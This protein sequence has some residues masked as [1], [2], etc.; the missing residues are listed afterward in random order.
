MSALWNESSVLLNANSYQEMWTPVPLVSHDPPPPTMTPGLGWDGVDVT[1][2]WTEIYKN[3]AV[4]GYAA[5]ISLYEGDGYGVAVA[6]NLSAA[7]FV[8]NN[9]NVATI[10]QTIHQA[11]DSGTV[12][13]VVSTFGS[14]GS[15]SV[16]L[17]GWQVN[18]VAS[19]Q[20]QSSPDVLSTTT[21]AQGQYIFSE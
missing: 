4:P 19:I 7:A 1:P 21:N 3:G 2:Q 9:P 11:L 14:A 18:V 17:A 10:I 15:A 13:G 20:G 16:P 8:P 5:Q 12:S 6:Y